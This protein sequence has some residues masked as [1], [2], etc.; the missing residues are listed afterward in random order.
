M[1]ALLIAACGRSDSVSTAPIS[2]TSS[3]ESTRAVPALSAPAPQPTTGIHPKLALN[4]GRFGSHPARRLLEAA[5]PVD[6]TDAKMLALDML[7]ANFDHITDLGYFNL[8]SDWFGGYR[9]ANEFQRKKMKPELRERY[10]A[11]VG[12]LKTADYLLDIYEHPSIALGEYSFQEQV[13]PLKDFNVVG[14]VIHAARYA[15]H[16][17]G[18]VFPRKIAMEEGSAEELVNKATVSGQSRSVTLYIL[19]KPIRAHGYV[20]P[21]QIRLEN[22]P[23]EGQAYYVVAVLENTEEVLGVYP[24]AG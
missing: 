11:R 2:R 7:G 23:L 9:A 6:Y 1:F 14:W 22:G 17:D 8:L 19:F 10:N 5:P 15:N 13:F 12:E 18:N 16:R 4:W 24:S 21:T 20:G 3:A